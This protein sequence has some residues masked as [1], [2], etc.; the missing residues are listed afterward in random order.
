[1]NLRVVLRDLCLFIHNGP[2]PTMCMETRS[3]MNDLI[4]KSMS[5]ASSLLAGYRT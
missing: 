4:H 1:M 5:E 3:N 2:K